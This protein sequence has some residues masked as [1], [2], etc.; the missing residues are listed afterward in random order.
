MF[1]IKIVA[2]VSFLLL[3]AGISFATDEADRPQLVA[4]LLDAILSDDSSV[5]GPAV[6]DFE[7]HL[8][9]LEAS[10]VE[11]VT[12]LLELHSLSLEEARLM[13]L[14][15]GLLGRIG[16]A[17]SLEN[18]LIPKIDAS[19][20]EGSSQ[21]LFDHNTYPAYTTII[22][23]G[24][25]SIPYILK[26]LGEEQGDVRVRLLQSALREIVSE[27]AAARVLGEEREESALLPF[28]QQLLDS[29]GTQAI[30]VQQVVFHQ[31]ALLELA[32]VESLKPLLEAE[33][34]KSYEHRIVRLRSNLL[35][36]VGGRY[37]LDELLLKKINYKVSAASEMGP[38]RWFY[39]V[40]GAVVDIG[41]PAIPAILEA[42]ETEKDEERRTF[43]NDALREIITPEGAAQVIAALEAE[44]AE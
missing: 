5:A 11:S 6:D 34:L 24:P 4:V 13:W 1:R 41:A 30:Q 33:K 44:P 28:T 8:G 17:F 12:P 29:N 23:I 20:V 40:Y 2:A 14:R 31:A 21:V 43:L 16:G 37:A 38:R 27:A 18:L 22:S 10:L 35:G 7:R 42:L 39:P 19:P 25:A 15:L 32:L 3:L 26:A 36:N 9:E